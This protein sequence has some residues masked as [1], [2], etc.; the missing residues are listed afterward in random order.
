M[1]GS[2]Q[3]ESQ[4]LPPRPTQPFRP[5]MPLHDLLEKPAESPLAGAERESRTS[6]VLPS[7]AFPQQSA[8]LREFDSAD[9]AA[10]VADRDAALAY[11]QSAAA[12][13]RRLER[14]CGTAWHAASRWR[15]APCLRS[16]L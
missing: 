2:T 13:S 16:S 6:A 14:A 9:V 4:S 10:H 1:S 8:L 7:P 15:V 12:I 5:D 11:F 3:Q